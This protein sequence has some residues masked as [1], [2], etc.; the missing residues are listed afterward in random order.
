M[1]S[2]LIEKI[3]EDEA[4]PSNYVED[5]TNY[6]VPLVNSIAE[7]LAESKTPL[8]IGISGAQGTGK[9]TLS[10]L[11]TRLLTE[12]EFNIAKFSL[13]DFY[14]TKNQRKLLASEEHPLLKTRGVPGTHDT[15]LLLSKLEELFN[16]TKNR[17]IEI[18]KFN[19]ATDER[20]PKSS[21]SKVYGPVDAIVM[22]GWFLGATPI[23]K[24]ML[25]DPI[26]ELEKLEDVN[27]KWREFINRQL[28]GSYQKIFSQIDL[29]VLLEA[30]SFNQVYDWR[31]LQE[32]KLRTRTPRAK[33]NALMDEEQLFRFIQ[34]YER[35]TRH[36]LKILPD[37]A[38]IIFSLNPGHRITT[39][40]GLT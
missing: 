40:S 24:E 6:F 39:C 26:N 12:R 8:M 21:W 38:D 29:L 33:T 11:L 32:E 25:R 2:Q 37:R 35:L 16:K 17:T 4:L 22:E 34:H 30:P 7:K 14:L 10:Y 27:G 18:P 5:A 20:A 36:C 19:K 3:A 23:D 28:S 31:K 15:N 1:Y 9:T 13:D